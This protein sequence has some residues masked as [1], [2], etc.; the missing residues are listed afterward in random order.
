MKI[1]IPQQPFLIRV[2]IRKAG[3]KT[4][5]LTFCETTI[6]ELKEE[7]KTILEPF[8]NNP[9]A[10]G[11]KTAVDL[12]E[13]ENSKNGISESFSFKGINPDKV[14]EIIFNHFNRQ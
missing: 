13:S 12:R 14:R 6:K 9:Y 7:L 4:E 5:H 1:Y 2:N 3:E 10:D 8:L 11:K